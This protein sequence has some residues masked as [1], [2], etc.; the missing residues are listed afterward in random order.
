MM[1]IC[2][3]T[4]F[5]VPENKYF[6]TC[7]HCRRPA[8]RLLNMQGH[9]LAGKYAHTPPAIMAVGHSPHWFSPLPSP[10]PP[11]S[12]PLGCCQRDELVWGGSWQFQLIRGKFKYR[13][14]V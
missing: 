8:G 3:I 13:S 14:K 4:I 12:R 2:T 10:L 11:L 5:L 6:S 9:C 1:Y 7:A